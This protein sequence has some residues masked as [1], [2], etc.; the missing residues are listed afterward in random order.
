MSELTITV[1]RLGLLVA[2]W[3]FVI[4][5]VGVLR[6]DLYGTQVTPRRSA[7]RTPTPRP[8]ARGSNPAAVPAEQRPV[9]P[10]ATGRRFN[11]RSGEREPN[12]LRVTS[13]PLAGTSLPLREAGILIGRSPES[14]L[15]LEDDFASGRHARIYKGPDG[16]VVEDLGSTNGTFIGPQRLSAPTPVTDGTEIRFGTTVVELRR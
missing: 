1:M 12:H 16:W 10:R 6:G 3:A 7:A 15:V 2:L 9:R 8:A 5:V 14:A 4:A 13:G 11:V